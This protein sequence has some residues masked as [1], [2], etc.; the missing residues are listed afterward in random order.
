MKRVLFVCVK[1]SSR[2]QMAE[3]LVK[4]SGAPGIEAYSAGIKPDSEVNPVAV[5]A[6][7][8]LGYDLRKHRC[9]HVTEFQ[10]IKFDL[11]AKMDVEDLGDMVSAKWIENWDIPDPAQ[12][13]VEEMR[14]VR[15]LLRQRIAERIKIPVPRSS[16]ALSK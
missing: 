11:V 1:N 15:E 14:Q 10:T 8:E 13:G 6:M 7:K 16:G 9:K 3:A 12:G 2:S 5:G 4:M